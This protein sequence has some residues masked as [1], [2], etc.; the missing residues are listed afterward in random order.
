MSVTKT[1]ESES[2]TWMCGRQEN[3]ILTLKLVAVKTQISWEKL[4]HGHRIKIIIIIIVVVIIIYA[5]TT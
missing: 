5:K 1:K 3:Y 2:Q 4:E